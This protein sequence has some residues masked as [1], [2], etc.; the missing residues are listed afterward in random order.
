MSKK[1]LDLKKAGGS[2]DSNKETCPRPIVLQPT[3][4]ALIQDKTNDQVKTPVRIDETEKQQETG[5]GKLSKYQYRDLVND[6]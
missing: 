3:V 6:M 5:T 1:Y 4:Q 2:L